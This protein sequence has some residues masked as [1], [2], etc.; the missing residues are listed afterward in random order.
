M[1]ERIRQWRRLASLRPHNSDGA[2]RRRLPLSGTGTVQEGDDTSRREMKGWRSWRARAQSAVVVALPS[3]RGALGN[4][5]VREHGW[6]MPFGTSWW[7]GPRRP[8]I[9]SAAGRGGG[10][11]DQSDG[12]ASSH[13][14]ASTTRA[15][16]S[17]KSLSASARAA[18]GK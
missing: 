17:R 1:L 3:Q 4:D 9:G 7:T 14:F 2:G 12:A 16:C 15:G 5:A 8:A 13:S 6:A 18:D 11:T 10:A